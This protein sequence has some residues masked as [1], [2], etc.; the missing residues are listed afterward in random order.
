ITSTYSTTL[1][2]S[3]ITVPSTT[4][5]RTITIT[6][7]QVTVY[8]TSTITRTQTTRVFSSTVTTTTITTACKTQA[9]KKD[10]PVTIQPTKAPLAASN[11]TLASAAPVRRGMVR[12][13]KV[14]EPHVMKPGKR[15]GLA[16]RDGSLAK[17]GPGTK[18]PTS[19]VGN[20]LMNY[21]SMYNHGA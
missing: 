4:I 17:R 14:R 11:G 18:H 20:I 7:S 15:Q 1:P 10:R 21:R 2:P 16:P 19:A 9:P 13:G 3:T 5:T 8:W 6:P 12:G